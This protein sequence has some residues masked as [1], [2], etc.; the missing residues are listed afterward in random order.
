MSDVLQ[1]LGLEVQ[2]EPRVLE[3]AHGVKLQLRPPEGPDWNVARARAQEAFQARDAFATA[4]KR[5]GWQNSAVVQLMDPDRWD[6]ASIFCVACELA[7]LIVTKVWRE[8]GGVELT[9]EP[10]L[11]VFAQLFK[12]GDSLDRFWKLAKAADL[13]LIQP[14]K[15]HSPSLST[16]LGAGVSTAEGAGNSESAE[17]GHSGTA[18]APSA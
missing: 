5:Y 15:E 16:S 12:Q 7:P 11:E 2:D 8:A 17:T 3:L 10:S 4:I 18:T 1:A 13:E 14:K 6:E 9:V